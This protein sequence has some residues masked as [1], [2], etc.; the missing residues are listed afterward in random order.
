MKIS[1]AHLRSALES[2]SGC[3]SRRATIP[4]LS[5]VKLGAENGKMYVAASDCDQYQIE[6]IDCDGDFEPVLVSHAK[7]LSMLGGESIQLVNKSGIIHISHGQNNFKLSTLDHKLFPKAPETKSFK[8]L[9]ISCE[10]LA[11]G[12]NAVKFTACKKDI[13][14]PILE[15]IHIKSS[16]KLLHVE[17]CDGKDGAFFSRPLIGVDADLVV[18][19]DF[20][21]KLASELQKKD[22]VLYVSSNAVMVKSESGLYFVK[23]LE[24]KYPPTVIILSEAKIKLGMVNVK[25]LLVVMQ[26]CCSLHNPANIAKAE[27]TFRADG[28]G[29]MFDGLDSSVDCIISG[30]FEPYKTSVNV[31]AISKCLSA[32]KS[33]SVS[34]LHNQNQTSLWFRDGDLQIMSMKCSAK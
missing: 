26:S 27:L 19:Y 11:E 9:G 22:A 31:N 29:V 1:T 23:L 13:G 14:K 3:I 8:A 21:G 25:E 28:L 2:V 30:K 15:S 33:E 32:I 34:V 18:P 16:P 12:I 17:A 24:G 10:D 7:L 4:A 6:V 5:C 20:A